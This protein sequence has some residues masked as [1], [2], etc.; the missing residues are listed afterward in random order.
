MKVDKDELLISLIEIFY[1]FIIYPP[2]SLSRDYIEG[3]RKGMLDIIEAVNSY[4][5]E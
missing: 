4:R 2:D 1:K 3:Y 5:G